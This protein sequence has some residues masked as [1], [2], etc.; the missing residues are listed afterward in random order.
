MK[1]KIISCIALTLLL[2]S[3]PG[4]AKPRIAILNFELNDMTSLPNAIQEQQRT[5]SIQPL[6][7]Q[8]LLLPDS[9]EIIE[10]STHAET[11]ANAGLG[12]LFSV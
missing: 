5:A 3:H 9:F 8:A 7:E 1:Q 12:Y 11:T 10:I 2:I 6:L 4:V